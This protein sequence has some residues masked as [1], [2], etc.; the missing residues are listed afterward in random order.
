ML[1]DGMLRHD[2]CATSPSFDRTI[3]GR[4]NASTSFDATMPI[5]PRCQ[6]SPATTMTVREPTSRSVSTIFF[7]SAT[8]SASSFWR[9]RFSASSC[10]RERARLVGHHLVGREQQ[11]RGDVG[12][13]H[14]A[15]RI[16]ARPDDEA[17]V[18][19]VDLLAGQTADVEQRPQPH[20]VRTR[21]QHPEPQL[22]D[23]PVF[24]HQRDDVRKRPDRGDL[25]ERRQPGRLDPTSGTAP[26]RASARR[27]RRRGSCRDRRSRAASD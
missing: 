15:G 5:T 7:A 24:T 13:A 22:G 9:R 25:D 27:R 16:H 12:R 4:W 20:L 11:A 21:R 3:A 8:I 1:N 23:D 2:P 6:P 17:D 14:A 19:A 18:I 26:A 10:S